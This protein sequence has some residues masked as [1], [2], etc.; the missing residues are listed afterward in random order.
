MKKIIVLSII[1]LITI[2]IIRKY[3]EIN[4]NEHFFTLFN[5]S[6]INQKN[7]REIIF[8]NPIPTQDYNREVINI[9]TNNY[10]EYFLQYIF[11]LIIQNTNII[12]INLIY[13]NDDIFKSLISIKSK[14]SDIA[15][16]PSPTLYNIHLSNNYILNINNDIRFVSNLGFSYI[17]AIT[18]KFSNIISFDRESLLD[19]NIVIG[20]RNTISWICGKLLLEQLEISTEDSQIKT[21]STDIA[22]KLLIKNKIDLLIYVDDNK[23]TLLNKFLLGNSN[24]I[25]LPIDIQKINPLF[26]QQHPYLIKTHV[27]NNSTYKF[28]NTVICNKNTDDYLIYHLLNHIH[29][30][31]HDHNLHLLPEN[32]NIIKLHTLHMHE[33]A[34]N[35]YRKFGYIGTYNHPNC[36]YLIG[37]E[38]CTKQSLKKNN[39]LSFN[40]KY[41]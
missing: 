22:I 38:E 29:N 33:S 30:I 31:K 19:K 7:S 28:Y 4:G 1:I 37:K 8:N 5:P 36:K 10:S 41:K 9:A 40:Y 14:K 34:N 23:N 16:I 25:H 20:N 3:K 39:L 13:N 11:K 6:F 15:I 21:I 32:I 17:Y 24:I 2:I 35:W 12:Y 27:G 26:L 18:N